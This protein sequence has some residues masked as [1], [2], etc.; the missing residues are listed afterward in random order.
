MSALIVIA[1]IGFG[2]IISVLYYAALVAGCVVLALWAL[3]FALMPSSRHRA[4]RAPNRLVF[5]ATA[6]EQCPWCDTHECL[7]RTQ[8]TCPVPCGSRIC[9]A[10]AVTRG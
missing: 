7:D 5:D 2:E 1:R 3:V 9:E 6:R 10:E 8:C 4:P